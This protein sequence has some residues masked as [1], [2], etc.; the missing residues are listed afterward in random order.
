[1]TSSPQLADIFK[2]S[3]AEI[4][5]D[6]T[7][8]KLGMFDLYAPAWGGVFDSDIGLSAHLG[9]LLFTL[10]IRTYV[11]SFGHAILVFF[12]SHRQHIIKRI[13]CLLS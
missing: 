8:I 12:S 3:L 7:C 4:S 1:M 11:L 5:Y 9:Y 6:A 10:Y 2:K 13:N